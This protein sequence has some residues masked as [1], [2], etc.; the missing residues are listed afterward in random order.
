MVGVIR[1]LWKR[2]LPTCLFAWFLEAVYLD[3]EAMLPPKTSRGGIHNVA[4][5]AKQKTFRYS[6]SWLG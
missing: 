4:S 5:P 2:N 6:Q 3:L 1:L